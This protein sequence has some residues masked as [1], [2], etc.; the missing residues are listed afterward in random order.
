[1][2]IDVE[3]TD[4]AIPASK[5]VCYAVPGTA[6]VR[7]GTPKTPDL[8]FGCVKREVCRS[9]ENKRKWFSLIFVSF[10]FAPFHRSLPDCGMECKC[11]KMC[12]L[13]RKTKTKG[14]CY[15][16]NKIGAQTASLFFFVFSMA[17]CSICW[18][19]LI[20]G[21]VASFFDVCPLPTHS[22]SSAGLLLVCVLLSHSK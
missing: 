12:L 13:Q 6:T 2:R 16:R 4:L 8:Q 21:S 18:R 10:E 3:S 22:R 15:K 19:R 1:M 17:L 11:V 7:L 14:V 9:M 20:S 5:F